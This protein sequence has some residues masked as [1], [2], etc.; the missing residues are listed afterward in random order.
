MLETGYVEEAKN[1]TAKVRMR[2]TSAC[3][4]CG[5]CGLFASQGS[6]DLLI[7]ARN[8]QSA[9]PGDWVRVEMDPSSVLLAAFIVYIVPL[10]FAGLGYPVGLLVSRGAS[11]LVRP[12]VSGIACSILFFFMSYFVIRL[13]DRRALAARRFM[14]VIKQIITEE[15][16]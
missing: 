2:R 14:P 11:L 10:V 5:K 16:P 9:L 7:V 12:E 3:S 1:D 15:L 13:C 4:S 8:D 6:G